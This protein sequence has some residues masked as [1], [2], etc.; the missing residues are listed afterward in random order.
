VFVKQLGAKP[1]FAVDTIERREQHALLLRDR[2]GGDMAEWPADLQI[3][4]FPT[5]GL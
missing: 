3:R 4:E 2:K 1:V 5:S